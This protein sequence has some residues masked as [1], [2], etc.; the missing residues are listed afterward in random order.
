MA[1]CRAVRMRGRWCGAT[2]PRSWFVAL[3]A[4][5]AVHATVVHADDV[6]YPNDPQTVKLI[7]DAVKAVKELPL[8]SADGLK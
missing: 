5:A 6:G 2:A 7:P 4:L 8:L 1:N 3:L